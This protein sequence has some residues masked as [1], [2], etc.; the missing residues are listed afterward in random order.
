MWHVQPCATVVDEIA[1]ADR[2]L[3]FPVVRRDFPELHGERARRTLNGLEDG[4][5][6][7][8]HD[9]VQLFDDDHLV[10]ANPE[11]PRSA[12]ERINDP[13]PFLGNR[14]RRAVAAAAIPV[15]GVNSVAFDPVN[16]RVNGVTGGITLSIWHSSCARC[17]SCPIARPP[18]FNH[19]R[20]CCGRPRSWEGPSFAMS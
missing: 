5:V 6:A 4:R 1:A 19:H 13:L 15:G 2:E 10:E 7:L 9:A 17:H 3:S 18:F 14:L 16:Q 12:V 11:A 8:K 20:A